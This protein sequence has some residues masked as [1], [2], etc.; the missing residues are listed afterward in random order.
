[1]SICIKYK[2]VVYDRIDASQGID[3]NKQA[4]QKSVTFLNI[5]I[6]EIIVLIFKQMS[7]IGVMI[8]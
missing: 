5:G 3:V 1:M 6:S 2:T 4:H 8:Y 7:A